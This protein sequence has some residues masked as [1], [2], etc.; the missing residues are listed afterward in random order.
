MMKKFIKK[1]NALLCVLGTLVLSFLSGGTLMADVVPIG[2]SEDLLSER[3]LQ[4]KE[5]ADNDR[6]AAK[7]T[8]TAIR[9]VHE[10]GI[11]NENDI[12]IKNT[13]RFRIDD[14]EADTW[15]KGYIGKSMS[16]S[17]ATA[18]AQGRLPKTD[19]K[20]ANKLSGE[21]FDALVK[22]GAID[23]EEWH[24][25]SPAFNKTHFY[26]WYEAGRE[27]YEANKAEIDGMAE[28]YAELKKAE[29][30]IRD[31][32][33]EAY[34]QGDPKARELSDELT[35]AQNERFKAERD[36][37]ARYLD[38]ETEYNEAREK[39][40]RSGMAA[41]QRLANGEERVANAMHRDDLEQYG[42]TNDITFDYGQPGDATKDYKG[43]YGISHIAAK[44]GTD[45]LFKL[46]D[47]I[48]SGD[49]VRY[50]DGNKTVVIGK[51]GYEA[52]LALT[53]NGE[54]GDLGSDWLEVYL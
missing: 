40:V 11:F 3:N 15:Q 25:T 10:E 36:M 23:G 21:R 37:Q 26:E 54:K 5:T 31:R 53:R 35:D 28:R 20:K 49:V 1:N 33:M 8:K 42:G 27:I 44:H 39:V 18:R 34:R 51:D 4:T 24:H 50:V 2:A 43:G 30:E 29:K 7:D 47:V 9:Q 45:T 48:E 52:V 6:G 19:F 32:F 38:M 16:K 14:E 17:A 13:T 12:K 46:L 41:L 22:M